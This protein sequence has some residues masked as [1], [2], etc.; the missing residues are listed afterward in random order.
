MFENALEVI[1]VPDS[2]LD[3]CNIHCLDGDT[4]GGI[5]NQFLHHKT[6]LLI[7]HKCKQ[8]NNL[9]IETNSN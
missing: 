3:L 7:Q 5:C 4:V 9:D 1:F 2:C 8:L 6:P